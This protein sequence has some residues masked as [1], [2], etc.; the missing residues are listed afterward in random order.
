MVLVFVAFAAVLGPETSPPPS[1]TA[2]VPATPI[3]LPGPE[4]DQDRD[5]YA[6]DVDLWDGDLVVVLNVSA[7]RVPGGQRVLPYLLVGTEDDHWRTG[8]GA[9]LEWRRVVDH[10]PLGHRPGSPEW[11][12]SALR[13]GAWWRS[14][15]MEGESHAMA[16]G[17]HIDTPEEGEVWPQRFVVNVR[18]DRERVGVALEAWD[19]RPGPHVKRGSWAFEVD[20]LQERWRLS[21][22]DSWHEAGQRVSFGGFGSGETGVALSLDLQS[23]L[24]WELKNELA[25]RW[26]PHLFFAEDELFFPTAGEAM[27]QFHGFSDREADHRTWLQS[28]NNARNGYRLLLADFTGDGAV[29][30]E[31][32]AVLYEVLRAGSVAADRVYANVMRTTGDHVVVQFW[33]L[34]IYNFVLDETGRD[35]PRLAH[36]GDRE[37]IQL[38]FEDLDAAQN[39]TPLH[40]AYS[41]HYGGVKIPYAPGEPPFHVDPERPAVFVALGSHASY[42]AAGTDAAVRHSLQGFGDVFYGDGEAWDPEEYDTE[43]L[44]PQ[45]WHAGYLWGPLTRHSRDMG[46]TVRPLLQYDFSYPFMDPLHWESTLRVIEGERLAELYGGAP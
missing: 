11:I 42:P 32:A 30:R 28:F 22:Q 23:D 4:E 44:G 9:E 26:A 24:S 43:V 15:A 17:G 13:T 8:A 20:V 16:R 35:I 6:D 14:I 36:A 18:D 19:A 7:L 27:E 21:G 29:G 45:T 12:E 38:V 10:D 40:T 33:F 37:F 31:D 34:S 25:G 46:T 39:G 41:Q 2:A 5:T 3:P 1:G